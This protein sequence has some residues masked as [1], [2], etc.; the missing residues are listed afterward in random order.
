MKKDSTAQKI[1]P[2]AVP[3]GL[4]GYMLVIEE[5]RHGTV[6]QN[7]ETESNEDFATET[8]SVKAK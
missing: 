2:N 5:P 6:E 7:E 1:S 8:K 3:R 4:S